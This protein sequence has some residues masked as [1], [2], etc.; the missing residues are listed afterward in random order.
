MRINLGCGTRLEPGCVN[1]DRAAVPGADVVHDLDTGPWPF[2]DGE[3]EQII[4]FD[5]FEH[6]SD[7]LLFMAECHRILRPGGRLL[8]HTTYWRSA[9]A[10][11]DPTHKRFCTEQTFDYWIAGT[12][13]H[14]RYG[15][16]YGPGVAF[17]LADHH[18]EGTEQSFTLEKL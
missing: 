15:P 11:T 17:R 2:G 16:A 4:A 12:D 1:V 8:I 10:F 13:F 18:F 7:P 14:A 6:V 3:A 9:N 5:V